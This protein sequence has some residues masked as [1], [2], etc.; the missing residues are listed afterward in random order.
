MAWL[1]SYA[2]VL[3]TAAFFA[4]A[5]DAPT[6]DRDGLG[7]ERE[8]FAADDEDSEQSNSTPRPARTPLCDWEMPE[9]EICELADGNE[10]ENY[11]IVVDGDEFYTPCTNEA[12]ECIPGGEDDWDT[13]C[14]GQ[15]CYWDGEAF[16][17][18]SWQVEGV[19]A[20]PLVLNFDDAP[21]QFNPASSAAFDLSTDGTCMSTDWPAAPWLALD[22]DGDGMISS[23][24]E[25]FGSAT[26]MASGGHAPHGFA[27]LAE[28]EPRAGAPGARRA[29]VS[30]LKNVERLAP[31]VLWIDEIDKG[32]AGVDGGRSD[33]G[34]TA[35]VIGGLLT[36]L[37]ERRQPVFVAATANRV[38]ALPP[39]LLRRGRL[40]EIFFVDLPDADDREAIL[41]VHLEHI[42]RHALGVVP[43]TADPWAAFAEVIR[44]AQ[45]FCGAEIEAALTEARLDAFA[46]QRPLCAAD[47]H[48]AVQATVPLSRTRAESIAAI[49]TW[50]AD[51]ARRA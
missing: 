38:D 24:A 8:M 12:W 48:R 27:A 13:G 32:L 50:A 37:Q 40:D 6:G 18:H 44:R 33:A 29:G 10:G 36:W 30:P 20:T 43:P 23:G 42:P 19:C 47:L 46:E 31:V 28:L 26:A 35:R 41:R 15:Y 14:S 22:R 17:L 11:C 5:C 9:A 51:R 7:R 21:V 49:R 3:L 34:T 1:R 2:P 25:L 4:G 39:E 45:G 16:R